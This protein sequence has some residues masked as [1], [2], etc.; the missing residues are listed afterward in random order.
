MHVVRV[1]VRAASAHTPSYLLLGC[2]P[3]LLGDGTADISTRYVNYVYPYVCWGFLINYDGYVV[4]F[5]ERF[6]LFLRR[7]VTDVNSEI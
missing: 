7:D 6:R 1:C 5:A 4:Y 2:A 3:S